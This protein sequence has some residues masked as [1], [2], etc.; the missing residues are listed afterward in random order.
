MAYHLTIRYFVVFHCHACL[1]KAAAL[2]LDH[3]HRDH[4]Q[5]QDQA[6]RAMGYRSSPGRAEWV[7]CH[8]EV[9][10]SHG[11]CTNVCTW[12]AANSTVN[13]Q[14]SCEASGRS[15]LEEV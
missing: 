12:T 6:R 10:V 5:L 1:S 3:R 4:R 14:L 9:D 11:Q 8:L 2:E 15:P 7:S 13:W